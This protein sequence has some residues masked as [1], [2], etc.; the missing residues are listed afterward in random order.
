[1]SHQRHRGES[2]DFALSEAQTKAV[3]AAC[4]ELVERVIIGLQLWLG[5][6]A[7][8]IVHLNSTWITQDGNLRIP[9]KQPCNCA[10]CARI[11]HKLWKPKT[12][13]GARELPIPRHFRKDLTEYLKMHP[14]GFDLSRVSIY[15]R[16]KTVL[17]R[18]NV[19]FKG[20][21]NDT[22]FPHCMRA[23]C[24]N[25]LAERGMS[26]TGLAYFAGW[27]SIAVASHYISLVR[28]KGLALKEARE[29]FG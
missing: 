7:S 27:S 24:F 19:R 9:L 18:A 1:M 12:K 5:L 15:N 6:R 11:R 4:R 29:I 8:E 17:K 25:M 3:L 26:A 13:A 22:G 23:T 10:E 21:A 14:H 16:T 2:V 20:L 28:A